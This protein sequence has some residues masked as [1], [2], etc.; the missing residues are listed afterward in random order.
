MLLVA[1]KSKQSLQVSNFLTELDG[2]PGASAPNIRRQ[3]RRL[4]DIKLIEKAGEGYRITEFGDI[5]SIVES[6][7]IP[8][9]IN[10]SVERLRDYSKSLDD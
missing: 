4:K 5:S 10:Q 8:F 1:R 2:K 9:V 6:Y 7:I 3:L